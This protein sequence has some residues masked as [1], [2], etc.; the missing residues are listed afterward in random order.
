MCSISNIE[1]NTYTD[2][3]SH[4]I[5]EFSSNFHY[6]YNIKFRRFSKLF[7]FFF[8]FRP[9][10]SRIDPR[11]TPRWKYPLAKISL[12]TPFFPF[13]SQVQATLK[14]D[15]TVFPRVCVSA[16][17]LNNIYRAVQY[18]TANVSK[19][20]EVFSF[21]NGFLSYSGQNSLLTA[22]YSSY[23]RN[24]WNDYMHSNTHV[25][26]HKH[27][28]D[29]HRT[30]VCAQGR[31]RQTKLNTELPSQYRRKIE[32]HPHHTWG[33]V[34]LDADLFTLVG[35]FVPGYIYR[36]QLY[37]YLLY[38]IIIGRIIAASVM[39]ARFAS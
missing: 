36:Y 14:R 16:L 38:I 2:E 11:A 1:P 7:F 31:N 26:V 28:Y 21:G 6:E 20:T 10:F 30:S 4:I 37:R 5:F 29:F 3:N 33:G 13:S 23:D 24:E 32:P 39:F 9:E 15:D 35:V 12:H 17:F 25:Y 27:I 34:N 18:L 22:S 8:F 19:G